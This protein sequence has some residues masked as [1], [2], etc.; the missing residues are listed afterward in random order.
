MFDVFDDREGTMASDEGGGDGTTLERELANEQLRRVPPG[1]R[2][3]A[4]TAKSGTRGVAH[5][6]LTGV[7]NH[8]AVATTGDP[9][10][11][12]EGSSCDDNSADGTNSLYGLDGDGDD[13]AA[14]AA[15]DGADS[16]GNG[17]SNRDVS[18]GCT[19]AAARG[20]VAAGGGRKRVRAAAVRSRARDGAPKRL[21]ARVV[22]AAAGGGR[23]ASNP[24]SP[25]RGIPPTYLP[26]HP[27]FRENRV[28]VCARR[29]VAERYGA[30]PP[31]HVA[32]RR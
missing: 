5:S 26:G 10:V 24:H 13:A 27:H 2:L 3:E 4:R 7:R 18:G 20:E 30:A 28:R 8:G 29:G 6:A 12:E 1:V 22:A 14:V 25:H 17:G 21:R 19:G 23:A 9:Y 15:S 32:A 31:A 11:E 16:G